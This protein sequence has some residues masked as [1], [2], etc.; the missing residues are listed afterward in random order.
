MAPQVRCVLWHDN[1]MADANVDDTVTPG[2]GVRLACLIRLNGMYDR[3]IESAE[4][5]G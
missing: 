5:A 2:A 3:V 1:E 4:E